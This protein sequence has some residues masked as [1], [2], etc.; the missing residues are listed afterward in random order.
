MKS[1][2]SIFSFLL[3][4]VLVMT[5][6]GC[7]EGATVCPTTPSG[8]VSVVCLPDTLAGAWTLKLPGGLLAVG[9]GDSTLY[10]LPVGDYSIA[11]EPLPDYATPAP[12]T[13]S[14][15]QGSSI[16]FQGVYQRPDGDT[17][18]INIDISPE[19]AT[20]SIE[21][22]TWFVTH[23]TGDAQLTEV[24]VGTYSINYGPYPDYYAPQQKWIFLVRDEVESVVANYRPYLNLPFPGSPDQL[25]ANFQTV[26]ESMDLHGYW[27]M[28]DEKFLT[29]LQQSTTDEFPDLGATLDVNEEMRI[30]ERMFSGDAVTDPDGNLIPGVRAISFSVFRAL[31]AWATSPS[32][33][34]IPN[35]EWAPFEVQ[36]LFDRGQ[37]FS[38]LKVDGII[39]F[40][41]TSR[42]SLHEGVVKDYYQMI[43]Q[44]DLTN[45]GFKSVEETNWGSVKALFR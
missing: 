12:D 31:D 35:A 5:L 17:G 24:P 34:V 30:S 22:N 7:D 43:G 39:K 27:E 6:A 3:M 23:G 11:W 21:G 33:D 1:Y 15:A 19:D 2:T 37:N 41:V 4:F 36:F 42:D 16:E 10:N 25:M 32:D 20:W 13:L 29:L 28:L 38:T 18:T 45:S 26:Y 8:T 40:Y 44:W 9:A 14:M